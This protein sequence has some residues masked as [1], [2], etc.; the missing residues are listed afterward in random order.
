M[1][2]AKRLKIAILVMLLAGL[3]LL[4]QGGQLFVKQEP[5]AP[6]EVKVKAEPPV[7]IS[8]APQESVSSGDSVSFGES[9]SMALSPAPR[10]P[11]ASQANSDYS[12]TIKK[13]K[14]ELQILP[15]VTYVPSEGVNIKTASKDETIQLQRDH[16]YNT[17]YQVLWKKKY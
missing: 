1:R 8:P 15:G 2:T 17:D 13:E 3:Y 11:A 7:S 16:S 5:P 9:G 6:P 14:K 10:T 12:Y 4:F